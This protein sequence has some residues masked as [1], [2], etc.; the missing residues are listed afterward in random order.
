MP[1]LSC[2]SHFIPLAVV[3]SFGL[4]SSIPLGQD[5]GQERLAPPIRSQDAV[6]TYIWRVEGSR[7]RSP[8]QVIPLLRQVTGLAASMGSIERQGISEGR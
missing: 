8:E 4:S 5:P 3:L 1:L 2:A 6:S 7:G